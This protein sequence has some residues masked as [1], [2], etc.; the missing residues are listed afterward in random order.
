M[1]YP[2]AS[3]TYRRAA[4]QQASTVG[5]VIALL[6]TLA[7]DLNRA[8]A[9]MERGDI[10]TRSN[11]LAHGFTILQHLEMM[12]DAEK[13]GATAK[14]LQ[15][16]YRHLHKGMLDAQFTRSSAILHGL[17][18]AV[19]EVREA[20]QIV[21]AGENKPAETKRGRTDTKAVSAKGSQHDPADP[22]SRLSFSC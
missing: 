8:S 18:K 19:L 22:E 2:S 4:T 10:Q 5:L 21:D 3:L 17:V 15:R 13:G 11:Q 20:W 9:A 1:T 14:Q 6:D 7:G 12:L 16:F